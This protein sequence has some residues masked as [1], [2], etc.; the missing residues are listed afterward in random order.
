MDF[1]RLL[2]FF[3]PEYDKIEKTEYVRDFYICK[4]DIKL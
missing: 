3:F 1:S 4:E 2:F